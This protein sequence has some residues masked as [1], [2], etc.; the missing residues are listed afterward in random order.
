ML[1]NSVICPPIFSTNVLHCWI[2][3]AELRLTLSMQ[4]ILCCTAAVC[5]LACYSARMNIHRWNPNT[6]CITSQTVASDVTV[7]KPI[8]ARHAVKGGF[9]SKLPP[10]VIKKTKEKWFSTRWVW[11]VRHSMSKVTVIRRDVCSSESEVR[12]RFCGAVVITDG[13]HLWEIDV[14][15]NSRWLT[16]IYCAST[17]RYPALG[18]WLVGV[19]RHFS[20]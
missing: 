14:T 11:T 19:Q 9:W 7:E 3:E 8:R 10:T 1:H 13:R 5:M 12:E 18:G 17:H 15:F 6:P 4:A 2:C 20:K 16:D